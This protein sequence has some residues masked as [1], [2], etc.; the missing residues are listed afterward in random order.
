MPVGKMH[1]YRH[2][3]AFDADLKG[4]TVAP[5]KPT[6]PPPNTYTEEE[7]NQQV[8]AARKEAYKEAENEWKPKLEAAQNQFEEHKSQ[9]DA[10]LKQL[11][12]RFEEFVKEVYERMPDLVMALVQRVLVST[13]VSSEAVKSIVEDTLREISSEA[14]KMDISLC[15]DDLA[16]LQSHQEELQGRYPHLNFHE[17]K[18]LQPGDCMLNSRFGVVDARVE[19]K[20][21]KIQQDLRGKE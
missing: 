8:E 20:L 1:L 18:N 3:A 13:E 11:D 6:E 4:L 10:T 7:L 16:K 5:Q 19:T 21:K 17:D 12:G 14:E 2:T 9:L 15:P